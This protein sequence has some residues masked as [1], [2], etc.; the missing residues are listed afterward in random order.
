MTGRIY[1][2]EQPST[3]EGVNEEECD[4]IM[5]CEIVSENVLK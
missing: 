2:I 3:M 1:A 4:K 5:N